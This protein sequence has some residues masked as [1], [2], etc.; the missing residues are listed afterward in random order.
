MEPK[1]YWPLIGIYRYMRRDNWQLIGEELR[2]NKLAW[3]TCPDQCLAPPWISPALVGKLLCPIFPTNGALELNSLFS[4]ELFPN[5][6]YILQTW[7]NAKFMGLTL[8]TASLVWFY[9]LKFSWLKKRM[10]N[11]SRDWSLELAT[12]IMSYY[13]IKLEDISYFYPDNLYL[14]WRAHYNDNK[15]QASLYVYRIRMHT[16]VLF[17]RKWTSE[18]TGVG[19]TLFDLSLTKWSESVWSLCE[20]WWFDAK[21]KPFGWQVWC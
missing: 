5:Y 1:Y 7:K 9:I 19:K 10:I 3:Y 14:Y 6:P 8:S 21:Q 17:F 15:Y 11:F 12:T 18:I 13:I 20:Q 2:R 4:S 16:Q